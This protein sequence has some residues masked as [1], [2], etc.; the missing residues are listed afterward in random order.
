[1]CSRGITAAIGAALVVLMAGLGRAQN[2]PGGPSQ[3]PASTARVETAALELTPPERYQVPIAF[4]PYRRVTI[5]AT[6]DGILRSISAQV[7][8]TVR[9]G[10]EV[11]DLDR[12]EVKARLKVAEAAVKEMEA[13]LEA[14]KAGPK[15]PGGNPST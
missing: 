6:A 13:E 2:P 3:A 8:S 12:A 4:E 7:G 11:A 5:M 14:A 15:G 10:Q 1:M 9:E